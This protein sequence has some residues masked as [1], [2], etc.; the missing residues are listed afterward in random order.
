MKIAPATVEA[1]FLR[2]LNRFACLVDLEGDEEVV[3]LPNSGRLENILV[4]GQTVFL[5]EKSPSGRRTRYDLTMAPVNGRFVSVD[6]RVP[7]QLFDEAIRQ[8]RLANFD[9]YSL[10]RREA[11]FGRS[12]LDFLLK[13]RKGQLFVEI[14]SVTLVEGGKALFPDAPTE[15]GRRHLEDLMRAKKEGYEAAVV[16]M[17]Q[18]E[19]ARSFSPNDG[20]D[21]AFA[22]TL[23]EV[24]RQGV[25]AYCYGCEV[26][27]GE[28]D[29]IGELA[30]DM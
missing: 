5:M 3:Y 1:T 29:I 18:R 17:V 12:R 13:G 9:G 26:T 21:P 25:R 28:I 4:P 24:F 14:K 20:V 6:S 11:S 22:R 10:L 15:R 23:R 30:V 19:D 27:L 8:K 2:R 7:A 16:F